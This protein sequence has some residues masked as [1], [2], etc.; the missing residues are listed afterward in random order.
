MAVGLNVMEVRA[1]KL[2]DQL[3]RP[4]LVTLQV[5]FE[6]KPRMPTGLRE[7]GAAMMV[8]LSTAET[9]I[10]RRI[11]VFSRRIQRS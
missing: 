2:G 5:I 1:S 7:R 11:L 10:D 4:W 8:L 6:G 9:G 3:V